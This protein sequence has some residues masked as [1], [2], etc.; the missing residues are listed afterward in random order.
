MRILRSIDDVDRAAAY[1]AKNLHP[2]GRHRLEKILGK[3]LPSVA[4]QKGAREIV[5]RGGSHDSLDLY[6][7]EFAKDVVSPFADLC[8]LQLTEN[9]EAD[10][11]VYHIFSCFWRGGALYQFPAAIEILKNGLHCYDDSAQ[12]HLDIADNYLQEAKKAC[13]GQRWTAVLS[14][15]RMGDHYLGKG[16]KIEPGYDSQ[17]VQPLLAHR[18]HLFQDAEQK[19]RELG[20]RR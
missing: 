9:P 7:A 2:F 20:A 5:R 14:N 11:V 3:D 15:A 13:S 17:T 12:L 8:G 6:I 19:L 4:F 18:D 1:L 16:L 10:L